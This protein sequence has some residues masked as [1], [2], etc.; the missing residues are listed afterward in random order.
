[1]KT[2]HGR[3]ILSGNS[4]A[5]RFRAVRG[6]NSGSVEKILATPGNAVERPPVFAG[7]DFC[8]GFF[9]LRKSE[10]AREGDDAAEF[11]IE[12]LDAMDVDVGEAL[13]SKFALLNPARESGDGSVCDVGVVRRERAGIG[14]C[15]DEA[16]AL[17][18]GM[19]PGEHRIVTGKGC[20][21]GL[22]R[23]VARAGTTLEKSSHVHAPGVGGLDALRWSELN[24]GKFLGFGKGGGRS[25]GTNGGTRAES[26]RR[27][28]RRLRRLLRLGFCL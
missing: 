16:V 1:V 5:E 23:D 3:G 20:E 27:A 17:R 21:R 18:G 4:I 26:R 22:Q 2:L 14:I 28:G 6:G 15:A 9:C 19:R 10:V 12:L 11:R 8:V 24:A 13:G 7:G 25:L